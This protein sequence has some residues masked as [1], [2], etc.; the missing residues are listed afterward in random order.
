MLKEDKEQ[1][2]IILAKLFDLAVECDH[3]NF[4]N[5]KVP[6]IEIFDL[7]ERLYTWL[8]K[9]EKVTKMNV[10]SVDVEI[11]SIDVEEK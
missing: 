9:L 8:D 5:L 4:S 1:I 11:K 6:Y 2:K 3:A 7:G 10:K